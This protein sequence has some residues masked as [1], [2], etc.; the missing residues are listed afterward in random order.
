MGWA[1]YVVTL[2]PVIGLVQVGVQARADRYTYLPLIG[3]FIIVVW[4]ASDLLASLAALRARTATTFVSSAVVAVGLTAAAHVEA[5]YW[6]DSVT[7]YERALAVTKNN[8]V[9]HNDLGLALLERGELDGTILH[10]RE[11]LRLD[12]GHPEAPNHLAT[13]LARQGRSAEAIA[14]YRAA[15]A[16]RPG[17]VTFHSNLGAVLADQGDLAAAAAEFRAAL[18]LDPDS[19]SAHYNMGVLLARE[20]RYDD[21]VRELAVA[22]K[23]DP[24]DPEIRQSLDQAKALVEASA[25]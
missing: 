21:A 11:A 20:Q 2:V 16:V 1:W 9:A 15:L 14:V 4:G 6:H 22:R 18:G 8:A 24:F 5:G 25:R 19:A 17:D 12:P 13:A 3:P 10:C 23:L 7:L